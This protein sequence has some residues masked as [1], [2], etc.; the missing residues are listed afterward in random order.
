MFSVVE[1]WLAWMGRK[2]TELVCN[3]ERIVDI[4]DFFLCMY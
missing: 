3:R 2:T 4:M 1:D